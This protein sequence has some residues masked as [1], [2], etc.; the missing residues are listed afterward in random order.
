M[1]KLLIV[2]DHPM[3]AMITE[4][5][6]SS[7]IEPYQACYAEKMADLV[8][9]ECH[10]IDI[11]LA[12]L[13]IPGATPDEVLDWINSNLIFSKRFFFTSVDDAGVIEKI[14]NSGAVY[15]S[16]NT[17]FKNIVDEVQTSLKKDKFRTDAP[18]RR[19]IYQSLIQ[20][21]GAQKPLTIKQAR[22][23]EHL[24]NGLSVKET[25]RELHVSPDTVKA[26][27]RD[28]FMRLD[29]ANGREAVTRFLEAKRMAERLYGRET[30]QKSISET[31]H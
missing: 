23:M 6:F 25:A 24:S 10:D 8:S 9:L 15:L 19:S 16:K 30:V 1:Q 29:V 2:E 22:V 13:Q 4:E 20:L 31:D 18:E 12:D 17:R 28:A 3:T 27:L 21:P 5:I 11:V 7:L 14:K 26:H